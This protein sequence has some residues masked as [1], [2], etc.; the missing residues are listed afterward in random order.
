MALLS[1]TARHLT[2]DACHLVDFRRYMNSE[3]PFTQ[4]PV[5]YF[6]LDNEEFQR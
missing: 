4:V 3:R 2:S 5:F 1:S 6:L